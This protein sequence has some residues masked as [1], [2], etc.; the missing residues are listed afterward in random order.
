MNLPEDY[1]LQMKTLLNEEYDDYIS[2]FND[3]R[4]YGMRVNTLKMNLDEFNNKK[5]YE[6]TPVKWCEEG[7]YY[8]GADIRPSKSP[9][10]HAGLYYLQEPSAMSTG[11]V[12]DVKPVKGFLMYALLRAEKA[13]RQVRSLKVKE[14]L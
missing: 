12:A 1:I 4:L 14:F 7:F 8:N 6:I 10:Y 3:E 9:Y 5:L 13:H 2:S 11:A